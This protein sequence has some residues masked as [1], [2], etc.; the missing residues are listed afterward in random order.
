LR[1][2]VDGISHSGEG[3][4]R[5][6]GKATFIPFAIP[7]ET[8]EIKVIEDKKN[9][10]RARLQEVITASPDRVD[11]PCPYYFKCGG[12]AYQHVSYPRQLELKRQVVKDSLKR[13]AGIDIEVNP[14]I[15]MEDPWRYRNKVEWHTGKES[16]ELTMGYYINDSRVL[17]G[18]DNCLLISQEM[19]NYSKYIKDNLQELKIPNACE[20][21]VRQSSANQELMLIFNGPGTSQIDFARMLN[22]QE[23][24]SIYSVDQGATQLHYGDQSLEDAISE[25]KYG[26]SPL[27]FFQVNP[28]QT[29]RLMEVIKDFAQ[30]DKGDNVLDA[31]CGIGS[32]ALGLAG[33]AKRVVGVE[34]FKSAVKDAKRNAFKNDISNC[35]FIKGRCEEIIPDLKEHFDVVILDPPRSGCKAQLIE[36][37]VKMAPKRVVYASCNPATLARDLAAFVKADYNLVKVQPIDMFPQT[38][39]VECVVLI[40]RGKE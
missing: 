36:S 28:Q 9:Y 17:M 3:V 6:D 19:Q 37:I 39:H 16:G 23:A 29:E 35:K 30:I 26:I 10:Q 21:I 5:I 22:Y 13:I 8:V 25:I 1:C 38:G 15:G 33:K 14:V 27:A 32:I 12:C 18:I 2:Y 40:T 20:V 31:Y 11:P 24:A 34:S 7:G 4:A